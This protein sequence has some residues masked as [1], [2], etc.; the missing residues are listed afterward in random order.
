MDDNKVDA[1]E[2]LETPVTEGETVETPEEVAITSTELE[3][4]KAKAAKVDEIEA[5]NRKLYERQKKLEKEQKEAAKTNPSGLTS[6]DLLAV[7][8]ARVHEDDI[9]RVERFAKSEGLSI[10]ESL[11]HPELLTVL[12]LRREQR[13]VA[14]ATNIGNVRA[15][16]RAMP[17]EVLLE[18]ASK[19][20]IPEGDLDI[21]RLVAAKARATKG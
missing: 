13:N 17:D 20:K 21:E 9:E 6:S 18:N 11:K 3:E 10:K 1:P 16:A 8:N 14:E 12:D 19:G 15:G 2:V 5:N 7:T 4:L